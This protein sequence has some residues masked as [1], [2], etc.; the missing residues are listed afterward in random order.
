[1]HEYTCIH[2]Y[3]IGVDKMRHFSVTRMAG[4]CNKQKVQNMHK[5]I[6]KSRKK[7]T[8]EMQTLVYSMSLLADL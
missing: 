7:K 8:N 3:Y 6:F 5:P 2:Y 1:M 4:Q